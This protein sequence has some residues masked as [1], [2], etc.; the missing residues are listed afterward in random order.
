VPYSARP[1]K[2]NVRRTMYARL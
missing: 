1:D 2:N